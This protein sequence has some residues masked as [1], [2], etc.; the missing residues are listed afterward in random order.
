MPI[1]DTELDSKHQLLWTTWQEKSRLADRVTDKRVA[2]LGL[3]VGLILLGCILYYA[4]RAK[5]SV[6][7]DH[8]QRGLVY[9]CSSSRTA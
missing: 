3:T 8:L 4:L 6:D 9:A 2:I 1:S 7:P 5:A